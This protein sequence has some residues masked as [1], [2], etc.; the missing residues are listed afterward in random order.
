MRFNSPPINLVSSRQCRQADAA[1]LAIRGNRV[2]RGRSSCELLLSAVIV[3]YA[4]FK[5]ERPGT[6][7]SAAAAGSP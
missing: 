6:H 5:S 4:Y 7:L 2:N 3:K 1:A